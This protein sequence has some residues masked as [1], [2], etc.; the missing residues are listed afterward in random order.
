MSQRIAVARGLLQPGSI[1]LL[2]EV[3]SALDCETERIM[4]ERILEVYSS[5]TIIAISHN[6]AVLQIFQEHIDL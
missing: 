2:D 6:K 5:K 4:Y 3:S 1:I